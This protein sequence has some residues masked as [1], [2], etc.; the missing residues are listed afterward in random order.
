M[1]S[2]SSVREPAGAPPAGGGSPPAPARGA[3]PRRRTAAIVAW[4]VALAVVAASGVLYATL[5]PSPDQ[6]FLGYTGWR[7]TQGDVP[8][9]D[10]A[11]GN[12]PGC[13][14]LHAAAV[15]LLGNGPHTWRVFD[16][17]LMLACVGF[18]AATA[19]ELWGVRAGWWTLVLYPALYVVLG[20]WFAGERDVVGAHL[21]FVALWFYWRGVTRRRAGYQVGTG[22]LLAGAVLVKPTFAVFGAFLAC[23]A[24]LAVPAALCPLRARLLH[25]LAAGASSVAGLLAGFALLFATGTSPQ[26]FWELAVESIVVRYGN[27]AAT[28]GTFVATFHQYFGRHWPW[29][30]LGAAAALAAQLARREPASAARNLLFPTLWITGVA[31]YVGQ[32]QALGY[33]LGVS[34]AATVPVLC[35][36]L[37]LVTSAASSARGWRRVVLAALLA[38][39]VLGTAKK[40]SSEFASSALWLTGRITAQEHYRAFAAGDG[41]SAGEAIALAAE[42]RERVPE[43]GTIL[44]WGRANAINFLAERRQPT[45]FHHNVVV[46]RRYLPDRLSA[47][48][49]RWF[50]EEVERARPEVCLVNEAE[51]DDT[52]PVPGA[53]AFL[54]EYLPAHYL[55]VRSVGESG[56]YFRR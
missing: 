24:L 12:W 30:S 36:G 7:V 55:R 51:L 3:R 43:G 44:V 54:R 29:I 8:Y 28:A 22:L 25:V 14:W 52:P 16:F 48:W 50:R 19:R 23:H 4:A 21:L 33:T 32:A 6:W 13:H 46:M 9:H 31:T 47:K 10:F 5:P 2:G 17:G 49:N 1:S 37:G 26:A 27:D 41:L 20:R 38:I 15:L 53:I 18:A 35:S 34:Y 11:D 45:R 39:P 42:L 40:W 56:L